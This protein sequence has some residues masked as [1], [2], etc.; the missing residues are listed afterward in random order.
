MVEL[1]TEL[2]AEIGGWPVLKEARSLVEQ[3]RVTDAR[4]EGNIVRGRVRG[5]ECWAS[6]SLPSR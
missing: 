6:E 2:L 4:R 3:G 1:S 5:A